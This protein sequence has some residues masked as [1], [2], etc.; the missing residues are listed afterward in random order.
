MDE[1]GAEARDRRLL[2]LLVLVLRWLREGGGY[3]MGE[4]WFRE[5]G[6]GYA[7]E[8]VTR[9]EVVTRRGRWLRACASIRFCIA[10][11]N[12]AACPPLSSNG[13]ATSGRIRPTISEA[14]RSASATIL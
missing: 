3:A 14:A 12:F 11:Y 9:W 7:R 2:H 6:G 1:E 13:A 5:G 8:V 10:S 4:R